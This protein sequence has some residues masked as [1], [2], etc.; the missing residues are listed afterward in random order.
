MNK[1][2]YYCKAGGHFWYVGEDGEPKFLDYAT[3]PIT[4]NDEYWNA[5]E[6]YCG[7]ND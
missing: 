6:K 7:C 4:D 5:E 1:K 3:A 2:V